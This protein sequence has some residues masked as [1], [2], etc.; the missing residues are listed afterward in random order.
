M[1][2]QFHELIVETINGKPYYSIRYAEDGDMYEGYSSY[3]LKVVSGYLKEYFLPQINFSI[4]EKIH[5]CKDCFH[6]KHNCIDQSL[7]GNSP[8]C[9]YY[10]PIGCGNCKYYNQTDK[11]I[12][13]CDCPTQ[14]CTF[15]DKWESV[16]IPNDAY[17]YDHRTI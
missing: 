2:K 4:P 16:E 9:R 7:R 14:D 15:L 17:V 1:S 8:T 13:F 10:E 12:P 3:D 5:D 11:N 6:S